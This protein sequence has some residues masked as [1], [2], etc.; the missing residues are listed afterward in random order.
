MLVFLAGLHLRGAGFVV[1]LG[2]AGSRNERGV[3]HGVGLMQQAAHEQQVTDSDQNLIDQ[4]ELFPPMGKPPNSV[5]IG[6]ARNLWELAKFS[7]QKHTKK[8]ILHAQVR[9]SEVLLQKVRAQHGLQ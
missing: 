7:V 5:L 8:R 6:H 9:Q 2:G 1:V 4:L 3:H